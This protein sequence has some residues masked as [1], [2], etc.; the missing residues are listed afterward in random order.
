M[1]PGELLILIAGMAVIL[2]VTRI[3]GLLLA[4]R[5]PQSSRITLF[6]E[7]LPGI[8]L[9]AIIAP[10]VAQAG[11]VGIIATAVVWLIVKRTGNI[12]LAMVAGVAIVAL[13]G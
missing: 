8:T 9:V 13:F 2:Y 4:D 10:D 1:T 6:L 5:L 3:S 12:A 11:W 7:A